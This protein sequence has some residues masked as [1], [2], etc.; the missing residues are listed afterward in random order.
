[1]RGDPIRGRPSFILKQLTVPENSPDLADKPAQVKRPFLAFKGKGWL[2]ADQFLVS[3]ANFLTSALL[4]RMLGV[5]GFGIFSMFYVVLQYSNSVQGYTILFPMLSLAPQLTVKH[6]QERFLAG[7]AGT[8]YAFSLICGALFLIAAWANGLHWLPYHFDPAVTLP[9]LLTIVFFQLQDWLRRRYYTQANGRAAF[10][11]DFISYG[12]QLIVLAAIALAGRLT[13][14]G[15]YY[16]IALTSL[17]AFATGGRIISVRNSFAQMAGVVPKIW[18]MGRDLFLVNNIQWLGSQGVPLL[19]ATLLGVNSASGIRAVM[20]LLG[21]ISVLFQLLDNVIP[22][23]A[24][25]V[26][27]QKGD[28]SLIK[29]LL[30]LMRQMSLV[31]GLPLVALT[32]AARPIMVLVFGK[33]FGAYSNLVL[34]QALYTMLGLAYR[35]LQYYHRTQGT[36]AL[37]ARYAPLATC[38]N[39]AL[40]VVLARKFGVTGAMIALTVGQLGN[41]LLIF[42]QAVDVSKR[43]PQPR[44]DQPAA[45]AS[46]L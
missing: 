8:Q 20:T 6:E 14:N 17:A 30:R 18:S 25:Q 39:I 15:A 3:G 9:Y 35:C 43:P 36:T 37:I 38:I 45:A 12:G 21:P 19:V 23:R 29:Y 7:V 40:C 28:A 5:H 33:S 22:V 24:V 11:N 27:V 13:I 1:M 46:D 31:I 34:W 41:V 32:L 44:L 2:L 4:A 10:W 16:V 42:K 26:W